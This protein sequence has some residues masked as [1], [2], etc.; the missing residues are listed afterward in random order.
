MSGLVHGL[1]GI[2]GLLAIAIACSEARSRISWRVVAAGLAAQLAI[3]GLLLK[4]PAVKPLFMGLN[5][6]VDA[7]QSATLAGT[8]FVFGY[9]GG[10]PAP[11]VLA[12]PSKGFVLAFQALPLVLIMSALS[13][14]LY[15]WR[16]LPLVVR[17][18]AFALERLLGLGGAVGMSAAA[19]PFL[20]M[21]ESPLLIRP[22]LA[23]LSRGELFV[24]MTG[25]MATIAGTVL[26]LYATFLSGIIPDPV[27]HLLT[28]TLVSVPAAVM[29]AKM[30]VPD[31]ARTGGH[32]TVHTAYGGSMDAVVRGTMDGLHL[33]G[34]IIA[35]LIVLVALVHL[36]NGGLSLLPDVAG[37]PVTLQRIMGILLAPVAWA[38]GIPAEEM[39]AAGALMGTKTV[40]NELLAYLELARLPEGVL[41]PRS[42]LIMTYGLCGFANLGSLGIM[43]AGLASM[44]PERRGEIV[45][46]GWRAMVSGTLS[47]CLTAATVGLLL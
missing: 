1:A 24:V 10:G 39:A 30:M 26:V 7:L 14:L 29:V 38:M 42:R 47:S 22:Y 16:I 13:A 28:A 4:V 27:G 36:A 3:A 18:F 35:M 8:S 2:A 20:G 31:D 34:A 32:Q 5:R 9:V 11:F 46:L 45:A 41:S 19:M 33:L 12:D 25:G 37:A 15:H 23:R 44:A 43:I 40:L 6:A 21:I 17:G